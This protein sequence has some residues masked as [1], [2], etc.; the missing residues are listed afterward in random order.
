MAK[1]QKTS[2][3]LR[4][5]LKIKEGKRKK[6]RKQGLALLV[7]SIKDGKLQTLRGNGKDR[8]LTDIE[9]SHII[10]FLGESNIHFKDDI[11][12]QLHK[13]SDSKIRDILYYIEHEGWKDAEQKQK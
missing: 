8:K 10:T 9:V 2:D 4:Q 3:E 13:I 6:E 12:D 11:T 5:E 7:D 1:K